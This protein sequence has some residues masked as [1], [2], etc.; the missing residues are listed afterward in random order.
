MGSGQH[1]V[2]MIAAYFSMTRR[3]AA[4]DYFG[5]LVW[6][7]VALCCVVLFGV[8]TV[9]MSVSFQLRRVVTR[10]L[11]NAVQLD[12]AQERRTILAIL[13]NI[14]STERVQYNAIPCCRKQKLKV[15]GT[16]PPTA[17]RSCCTM[18]EMHVL[19]R[20]VVGASHAPV[21]RL[22]LHQLRRELL[23]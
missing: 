3:K 13:L 21:R 11:Y 18:H 15:Y 17:A 1:D 20:G 23:V 12:T 8:V 7:F 22:S 14:M 5:G 2:S 16:T 9:V 19:M 6:L 4:C 10:I